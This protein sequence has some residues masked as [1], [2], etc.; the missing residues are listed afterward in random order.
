MEITTRGELEEIYDF[1]DL[2]VAQTEDGVVRLGDIGQ[3]ATRLF[4]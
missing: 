4:L 3:S 1:I 2:P